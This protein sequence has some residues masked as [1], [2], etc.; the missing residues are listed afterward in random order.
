MFIVMLLSIDTIVN[1]LLLQH[2][3][4]TQETGKEV[5]V[6]IVQFD[7]HSMKLQCI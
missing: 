3:M 5:F 7:P 4:Q 6:V 2:K 1:I